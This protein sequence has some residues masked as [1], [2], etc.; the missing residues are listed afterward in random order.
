MKMASA[1]STKPDAKLAAQDAWQM[2]SQK[3]QAIPQMVFIHSSCAYDNR[4]VV[5]ELRSLAPDVPLHGGTSCL[6]VMTE[7]GFHTADGFGLGL[8]GI[9]DPSGH[10]GVGI[11]DSSDDPRAAATSA[12]DQALAH[13]GRP[14]EVPAA[15]ITSSPPGPEELVI[16]AIEAHVGAKVPIIG[17]TV[18]DNDMSGQWQQFANDT[19]ARQAISIAV[20]FPSRDIGYAF[21]S[22]YEPTIHR[23]KATRAEGRILFE[24][25][26][27][28][29][30]QVYNEWTDGLIDDVL[31]QGGSMVP[32]ATFSPVGSPVG[33]VG[34]IPYY[35]LS[36]PVEVL[37][38]EAI[39]LYTDIQPDSEV[40]LMRGTRESL[41]TRTGRVAAAAVDAAPFGAG[42]VK[43]AL[44][45]FCAG[46]ML[47]VQDRMQES[48][49]A[50]NAALD[51]APFLCA[52]TLGEQGCFIGGENRHGNLMAAVLAFGP[53]RAER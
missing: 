23:G 15:V 20:L 28:P 46:C 41:A 2:L 4:A 30:A 27:R 22:G 48:V 29:A 43:A 52:F 3:L 6:G 53:V 38:N 13:A 47:A 14:G 11:A 16:H 33:Q 37:S 25:D 50:L 18:A 9:V 19:V 39:L 24:V 12:L 40:V 35:R 44:V 1:W 42:E 45:L 17:G 8:L 36:Y 31:P 49:A 7:A 34:G 26:G 32:T 10:Y 51:G 21:H 5:A